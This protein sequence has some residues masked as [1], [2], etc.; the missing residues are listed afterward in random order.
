MNNRPRSHIATQDGG[1][2]GAAAGVVTTVGDAPGGATGAAPTSVLVS[3]TLTI[4]VIPTR[5]HTTRLTTFHEQVEVRNQQD[6]ARAGG[7]LTQAPPPCLQTTIS[8]SSNWN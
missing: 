3:A 2:A 6:E 1:V 5:T 8:S 4:T 7:I